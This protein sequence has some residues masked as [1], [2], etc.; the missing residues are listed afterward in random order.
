M[1][2][3]HATPTTGASPLSAS[4]TGVVVA[5]SASDAA[6]VDAVMRHHAE[7]AGALGARVDALV[8]AVGAVAGNGMA[9]VNRSRGLLVDFCADELLPHAAA[10]EATLYPAAA[11]DQRAG[12]LVEA[13]LAEHRVLL[14]LVEDVRATDSPV[15][16]AATATALRVLF[17]VH[18]AKENDLILPLVAADPGVSLSAILAGMHQLLGAGEEDAPVDRPGQA[19]TAAEPHRRAC[20]CGGVEATDDAPVL[21]VR[22]V[23]HAIRHATVFG[24]VGAVPVAGSLVLVAP[25][26]P[27][28]LLGQLDEREPGAFS[29]TYDQRGPDAWRVRLTRTR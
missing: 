26:D 9:P 2:T 15:G 8:T 18:L 13:M 7:L 22:D 25:H 6:A 17:D 19:T 29:V 11:S 1:D 21:D 3:V 14:G 27:L 16:A 24:A 5:S 23:P 10:E 28:P 20:G 12:L 4:G